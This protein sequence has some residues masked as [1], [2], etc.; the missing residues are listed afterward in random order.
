[1]SRSVIMPLSRLSLPQIGS[2]PTSSSAIVRAASS[3]FWSS[4]A[5]VGL[6]VMMSRAVAMVRSF[7]PAASYPR[8][9]ALTAVPP[10]EPVA[11]SLQPTV[12]RGWLDD[13]EIDVE[14]HEPAGRPVKVVGAEAELALVAGLDHGGDAR[15]DE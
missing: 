3:M 1:M 2:A 9:A 5:Q 10:A 8:S 11:K 12:E 15:I 13:V 7:R 4:C 6:L 14:V